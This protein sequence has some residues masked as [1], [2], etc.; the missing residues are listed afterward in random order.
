[1]QPSVV[2][3]ALNF[4]DKTKITLTHVDAQNVV[5]SVRVPKPK[6]FLR[7]GVLVAVK[8]SV[9]VLFQRNTGNWKC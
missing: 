9:V 2:L 8:L 4:L 6:H 5:S 7:L 3:S 1:V